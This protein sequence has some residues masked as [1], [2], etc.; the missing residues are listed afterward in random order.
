[1]II[2]LR[3]LELRSEFSFSLIILSENKLMIFFLLIQSEEA[4][5]PTEPTNLIAEKPRC[6]KKTGQLRYIALSYL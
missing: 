2:K 1:M 4:V 3:G 5:T 6:L